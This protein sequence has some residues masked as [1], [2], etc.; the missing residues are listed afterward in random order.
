MLSL[1]RDEPWAKGDGV[2]HAAGAAEQPHA[3]GSEEPPAPHEWT[4]SA[5]TYES[6]QHFQVQLQQKQQQQHKQQ[7]QQQQQQQ[8]A[9][10]AVSRIHTFPAP[11]VLPKVLQ[12]SGHDLYSGGGAG[13]GR[14]GAFANFNCGG[15]MRGGARSEEG[16][17]R[18]WLGRLGLGVYGDMLVREG[19]DSVQVSPTHSEWVR[20]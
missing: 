18:A 3:V 13:P 4:E 12:P 20:L 11:P 19:W 1:G 15:G 5:R 8:S 14:G 2:N 7:Q 6:R 16:R 10:R 9:W 17:I